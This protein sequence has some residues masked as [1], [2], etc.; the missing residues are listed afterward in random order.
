[1][2]HF[3]KEFSKE[4]DCI[5]EETLQYSFQRDQKLEELEND[6]F[7]HVHLENNILFPRL[8]K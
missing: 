6:M 1:M 3:K 7:Q 4:E 5:M 2:C 8:K